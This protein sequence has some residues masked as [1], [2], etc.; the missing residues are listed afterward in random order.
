MSSLNHLPVDVGLLCRFTGSQNV[1]IE[2][3]SLHVD[4]IHVHRLHV[5]V[6][7]FHDSMPH[8]PINV[9]QLHR[10]SLSLSLSLSACT[11][12]MTI[13][14]L[15]LLV[16]HESWAVIAIRVQILDQTC[17]VTVCMCVCVTKPFDHSFSRLSDQ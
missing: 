4:V 17:V 13:E 7:C 15:F 6:P 10:S 9:I 11:P 1:L 16:V 8:T 5:C 2:P 12:I 14:D 3:L